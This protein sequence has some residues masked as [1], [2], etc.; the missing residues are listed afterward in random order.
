[1]GDKGW[2]GC[3]LVFDIDCDHLPGAKDLGLPK[4]LE[5]ANRQA[6]R[7]YYDFL[8]NDFGFDEKY[9]KIVFSGGR[10]YH[11]HVRDPKIWRLNSIER[12]EIVDYIMSF[13]FNIESR[14][15]EDKEEY[16]TQ[17]PNPEGYGWKARIGRSVMNLL[18]WLD[19]M[20]EKEIFN[21]IKEKQ[22]SLSKEVKLSDKWLKKMVKK[23]PDNLPPNRYIGWLG[24][25]ERKLIYNLAKDM[26]AI[27]VIDQEVTYDIHRFIRLPGSL[28]GSTGFLVKP[29]EI[30]DL[31]DFNPFNDA[32]T[33]SMEDEIFVR[34]TEPQTL[35]FGGSEWKLDPGEEKIPKALGIFLMGQRGAT[36]D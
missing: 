6:R 33:F 3:D 5:L 20:N 18:D 16:P 12:R 21:Y 31:G 15:K 30:D 2:K 4:Q 34:I 23:F 24:D 22:K 14:L 26:A 25:W 10:G 17:Y 1:M 36:C 32:L 11:I 29:M 13:G 9:I 35:F 19:D 8:L 27:N 28:H 7:L